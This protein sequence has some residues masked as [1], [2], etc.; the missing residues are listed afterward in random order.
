M[1]G[2]I[3]TL[4]ERRRSL[5]LGGRSRWKIEAS[6][7]SGLLVIGWETVPL[8]SFFVADAPPYAQWI[9]IGIAGIAMVTAIQVKLRH[10]QK[11]KAER[12]ARIITAPN[13][14]S[15]IDLLGRYGVREFGSMYLYMPLPKR[16]DNAAAWAWIDTLRDEGLLKGDPWKY[17]AD[18]VKDRI[19]QSHAD[20]FEDGT[21]Q[22]EVYR[23]D[24]ESLTKIMGDELP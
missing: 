23:V 19:K 4:D 8:P 11:P 15:L 1:N 2:S 5:P 12:S 10:R 17:K 7:W 14:L 22:F 13:P 9:A 21:E 20:L 6:F 24:L 16:A 3:R 18:H